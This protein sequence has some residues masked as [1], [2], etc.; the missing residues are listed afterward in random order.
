MCHGGI[1]SHDPWPRRQRRYHQTTPT[2]LFYEFV[3]ME[4]NRQNSI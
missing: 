2:G 1:R 3:S 4:T